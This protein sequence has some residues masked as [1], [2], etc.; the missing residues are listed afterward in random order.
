M[1]FIII[2]AHIAGKAIYAAD[3]LPR[4]QTN[5]SGSSSLK[6]TDKFPVREIQT[7]MTAKVPEALTN[8]N[9]RQ[10]N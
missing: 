4:I 5:L 3:F 6:L 10:L 2:I 8:Q 9:G 1:A 7:G